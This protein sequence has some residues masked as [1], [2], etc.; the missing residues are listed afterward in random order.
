[1]PAA[2]ESV[3]VTRAD[4]NTTTLIV[5]AHAR[6]FE[7]GGEMW[8][9]ATFTGGWGAAEL[10][11]ALLAQESKAANEREAEAELIDQRR[12]VLQERAVKRA[13]LGYTL[14]LEM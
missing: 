3:N 5:K 4:G 9:D 10:S 1:M 6:Q 12:R 13:E 2:G 14:G 7:M 8:I 11:P